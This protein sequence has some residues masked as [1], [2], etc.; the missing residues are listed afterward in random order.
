MPIEDHPLPTTFR[1]GD[2]SELRD[3]NG[4]CRACDRAQDRGEKRF[5]VCS[6]CKTAL[7]CSVQCQR[8]D[9]RKH[10]CV[11]VVDSHIAI[12]NAVLPA[13]TLL[14]REICKFHQQSQAHMAAAGSSRS[15]DAARAGAGPTPN[16][17][18]LKARLRD[19][20]QAHIISFQAIVA[21]RLALQAGGAA[22]AFREPHV[23]VVSLALPQPPVENPARAFALRW[24]EIAPVA[25]L[26]AN[27]AIQSGLEAS[28]AA[29]ARLA[30]PGGYGR[31]PGFVGVLPVF[32]IPDAG[33]TQLLNFPQ[34]SVFEEK[35]RAE[36]EVMYELNAK[37]V[38]LG[39]LVRSTPKEPIALGCM[40]KVA[41]S[42]WQW[43]PLW[44]DGCEAD[45]EW[46]RSSGQE[47]LR[48]LEKKV[49]QIEKGRV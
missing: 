14:S 49:A 38:E 15:R 1:S 3:K 35:S 18:E 36:L 4:R 19:F 28:A 6:G 34:N 13:L 26:P 42:K 22:A 44:K 12:V 24:V 40:K 32:F 21:A 33:A 31:E 30:G 43:R 23:C 7:Y 29:R 2:T 41:G 16:L 20:T 25:Q 48:V 8:A 47:R 10:K 27:P 9:W 46:A 37:Y 39:V 45:P 11:F 5:S 17:L